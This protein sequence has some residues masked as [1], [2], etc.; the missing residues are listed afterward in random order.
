[1]AI[2][3]PGIFEDFEYE[4]FWWIPENPNKKVP[5]ILRFR[6]GDRI[7]LSLLGSFSDEANFEKEFD[8]YSQPE[9]IVGTAEGRRECTLY[10][11]ML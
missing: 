10:K 2:D 11:S 9:I 1:M 8:E 7:T 5:G 3:S 4:G 6:V